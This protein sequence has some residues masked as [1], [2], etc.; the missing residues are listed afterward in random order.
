VFI[1]N[2][3]SFAVAHGLEM[4]FSFGNRILANNFEG[5]AICGIWGGFSQDLFIAHNTFSKNGFAGYGMER[6]DVNIDHGSNNRLVKN[7]HSESAC[8]VHLWELATSFSQK[9]WGKANLA[10]PMKEN[11]VLSSRFK[12]NG[13]DFHT[14]GPVRFAVYENKH[15][16]AKQPNDIAKESVIRIIEDASLEFEQT[17][18]VADDRPSDLK[19]NPNPVG[20]RRHLAGRQ[21]I[22]MTKWGPWDHVSPLE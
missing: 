4:T 11:F 17:H 20:A 10:H 7:V 13:V 14:R 15:D 16:S 19:I 8:A 2:D 22:I 6:G 1:A 21:N 3:F 12:G 5:N 18:D 9:P